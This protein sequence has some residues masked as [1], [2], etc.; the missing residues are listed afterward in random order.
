MRLFWLLLL[1]P[2][3]ALAFDVRPWPLPAPANSAQPHLSTTPGGDLLLS[4]IER[5]DSGGH[6]LSMARLGPS[7]QW[8]QTRQVASGRHWFVNWADVPAVQALPDG[9]LWAHTL[10]KRSDAPYAYDVML[11]RSG[12]GGRHWSPP[13][14][15]HDDGS[16]SEHGFVTL[17]PWSK[18]E[19]AVAWLDGRDTISPDTAGNS[20]GNGHEGEH[21]GG[22]MG[23]RA[24]VF[25][26]RLHKRFEWQLDA[27]TCDC[28]QT[29][30]ALSAQGPL[31]VY[32]DRSKDE[33][34]D[35]FL[36]RFDGK[37]WTPPVRVH[38]DDWKMPACPVNGPAVAARGNHAW[39][40]WY[41]AAGGTPSVRIAHS[42][43][44]GRQFAPMRQVASG[45]VQGRVD[46][47]SDA[48]GVWLLWMSE[49]AGRQSLWL[50]RY[51]ADLGIE[52]ERGKITDIAG[53]GRAT[54]FPR[55]QLRNGV[56]HVVW[57]EIVGG[58]PG[59]RGV[60]ARPQAG[61]R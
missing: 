10:E 30:S 57:T 50:A 52:L 16:A 36:T 55:L 54:G 24:A 26:G 45:D 53:S 40:A 11:R 22:M 25:D 19:L 59:L 6:R 46:L 39:V 8:Q 61:S 5:Q 51:R 28:C 34:R 47:A 42:A 29:D 23:L 1:M 37:H 14:I 38:A 60:T 44:A 32:R 4:W 20:H 3:A 12:D 2:A 41:T 9:S 56:A 31:L 7:G 33:I 49:T 48:S 17:L 58:K 18:T 43:D 27:S 21:G 13:T 15:A 35:I